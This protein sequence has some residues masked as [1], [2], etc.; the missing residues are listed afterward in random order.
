MSAFLHVKFGSGRPPEHAHQLPFAHEVEEDSTRTALHDSLK[1]D[2]QRSSVIRYL[3]QNFKEGSYVHDVVSA[4]ESEHGM[5]ALVC[6]NWARS[7]GDP[8]LHLSLY[9]YQDD[10]HVATW[11]AYTDRSV[12]YSRTGDEND[13]P[14]DGAGA[15]PYSTAEA[16]EAAANRAPTPAPASPDAD[17]PRFNRPAAAP[18]SD[19]DGVEPPFETNGLSSKPASPASAEPDDDR[20]PTSHKQATQAR[21]DVE[22]SDDSVKTRKAASSVQKRASEDVKRGDSPERSAEASR[23]SRSARRQRRTSIS[24]VEEA[25]NDK[26]YPI[27]KSKP[28]G[29]TSSRRS[30]SPSPPPPSR[31][32]R[33]ARSTRSG[34]SPNRA[35]GSDGRQRSQRRR[36]PSPDERTLSPPPDRPSRSP[37][38]ASAQPS[39]R[40][41]DRARRTLCSPSPAE[42][43]A[44]RSPSPAAKDARTSDAKRSS[45]RR[46]SPSPDTTEAEQ[47]H[48]HRARNTTKPKP[49]SAAPAAAPLERTPSWRSV[50]RNRHRRD[51]SDEDTLVRGNL[52]DHELDIPAGG[53][54]TLLEAKRR[55]A[56]K[57][58]SAR[59]ARHEPKDEG[60]DPKEVEKPPVPPP[61]PTAK[62]VLGGWLKSVGTLL[63]IEGE[64]AVGE[65]EQK[66][67][68]HEVDDEKA[69]AQRKE[70]RRLRREARA[71]RRAAR[72]KQ[73][74]EEEARESRTSGR[75]A[76]DAADNDAGQAERKEE[77]KADKRRNK[78]HERED[79][80]VA[81]TRD[82]RSSCR[83]RREPAE[84]KSLNARPARDVSPDPPAVDVRRE[85]SSRHRH[86]GSSNVESPSE[87]D[88]EEAPPSRRSRAMSVSA[89]LDKGMQNLRKSVV[90]IVSNVSGTREDAKPPRHEEE[91]RHRERDDDYHED[92][93]RRRRLGR[94]QK[95]VATERPAAASSRRHSLSEDEQGSRTR[96]SRNDARSPPRPP[97]PPPAPGS[98]A[99]SARAAYD[100]EQSPPR[101]IVA[102]RDRKI[103]KEVE[104]LP[105]R[106]AEDVEDVTG[107]AYRRVQRE[108]EAVEDE[109]R[110]VGRRDD[111]R[112]QARFNDPYSRNDAA[113]RR[114]SPLTT[115]SNERN[116]S[117]LPPI[118]SPH[119]PIRVPR[120]YTSNES[121]IR[122]QP[123]EREEDESSEE[124]R[125][126]ERRRARSPSPS[127]DEDD[128]SRRPRQSAAQS[129]A[130]VSQGTPYRFPPPSSAPSSAAFSDSSFPRS[131]LDSTFDS[132][133]DSSRRQYNDRN[134]RS[135]APSPSLSPEP[136]AVKQRGRNLSFTRSKGESY[137]PFGSS[138]EESE[139]SEEEE[140]RERER[141]RVRE[142]EQGRRGGGGGGL[143]TTVGGGARGG[144]PSW[145][146]GNDTYGGQYEEED[147]GTRPFSR[148]T[149]GKP[150]SH[151]SG[152]APSASR[153]TTARPSTFS[154]TSSSRSP[155]ADSY[156]NSY[157]SR[158]SPPSH[159]SSRYSPSFQEDHDDD[160]RFS[161]S[162][163]PASHANADPSTSARTRTK[164]GV[165]GSAQT[166]GRFGAPVSRRAARRLGL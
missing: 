107:E 99:R 29:R 100:R 153:S 18:D 70:E 31:P 6:K 42:R 62:A 97:V 127:D 33:T 1:T 85:R 129:P 55:S 46:R 160:P 27:V 111:R 102:Q 141:D 158:F 22:D 52:D 82:D 57:G 87:L 80:A 94:Q 13:P 133:P 112:P 140:E 23:S 120:A 2:I 126:K 38:P 66:V 68:E 53:E 115:S 26:A 91:G 17:R 104:K 81:S 135:A 128:Y 21:H 162:Q 72:A 156:N 147:K 32:E 24:S 54:T 110:R 78:Q 34:V 143:R 123:N 154:P 45:R 121:P 131:D 96:P 117:A 146:R 49:G 44:S 161:P 95:D 51:D 132:E 8:K 14:P 98:T 67:L 163:S 50:S 144:P 3:E 11:H 166:F 165:S 41:R 138:S 65:V 15:D 79:G 37:S 145:E 7:V 122:P 35:D 74:E 28:I 36:E 71:A 142:R 16:L 47:G 159:S 155:Y 151:L 58:R 69:R 83:S 109:V 150:T 157:D 25:A 48:G 86:H 93:D 106:I 61:K 108:V 103:L 10:R 148:T 39:S 56:S 64:L 4:R 60:F 113:S 63:K 125:P 152:C 90:D 43:K 130:T 9:I 88:D 5:Y 139:D 114:L 119:S 12:S 134:V 89:T 116:P 73:E 19:E 149:V 30:I 84:D 101:S 105:R 136:D 75:A 118:V 20:A 76:A 59:R 92:L 164:I 40:A 124:D 137:D 77:N